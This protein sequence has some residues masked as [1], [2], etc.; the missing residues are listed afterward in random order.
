[1]IANSFCVPADGS[2]YRHSIHSIA[3]SHQKGSS[4]ANGEM[5]DAE[6]TCSAAA[7]ARHLNEL[8]GDQRGDLGRQTAAAEYV[9]RAAVI[10]VT[11][12]VPE[13]MS[14]AQ[15]E[16]FRRIWHGWLR[17]PLTAGIGQHRTQDDGQKKGDMWGPTVA[18][19]AIA[20]SEL[21]RALIPTEFSQTSLP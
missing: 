5:A 7:G 10:G 3:A 18:R 4:D 1:V 21:C 11:W 6:G 12:P 15:L 8:P 13:A 19:R 17:H 9:H 2:P 16:R 20:G 14:D